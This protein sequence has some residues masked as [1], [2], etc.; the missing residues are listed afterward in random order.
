[1]AFKVQTTTSEFGVLKIVKQV[2]ALVENSSGC[3]LVFPVSTCEIG[4]SEFGLWT[5]GHFINRNFM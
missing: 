2:E 1:M 4:R 3:N 5:S